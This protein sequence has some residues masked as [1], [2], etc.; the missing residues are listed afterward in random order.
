MKCFLLAEGVVPKYDLL[1]AGRQN[2][3]PNISISDNMAYA[4]P[5]L[6]FTGR[7]DWTDPSKMQPL[8]Q[9]VILVTLLGP[10]A[11]SHLTKLSGTGLVETNDK[12]NDILYTKVLRAQVD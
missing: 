5:L 4:E 9:N 8:E 6:S 1:L 3:L 11:G 7:C 12:L 2:T 10:P